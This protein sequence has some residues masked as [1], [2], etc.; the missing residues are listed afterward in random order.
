MRVSFFEVFRASGDCAHTG[1][2]AVEQSAAQKWI[3][4]HEAEIVAD[5]FNLWGSDDAAV[6][7]DAGATV[8]VTMSLP[9]KKRLTTMSKTQGVTINALISKMLEQS[10]L[11][12]VSPLN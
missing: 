12:I 5:V 9:L 1:V 2:E 4:D 7:L 6:E 11:R 3:E 10:M 8:L